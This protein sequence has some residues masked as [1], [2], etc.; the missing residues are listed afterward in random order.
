MAL[1][2]G[3]QWGGTFKGGATGGD[4]Q[5]G[6]HR[7]HADKINEDWRFTKDRHPEKSISVLKEKLC[8]YMSNV[9]S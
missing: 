8:C 3:A 2:G 6:F 1:R 4:A 9:Y 7:G 5:T